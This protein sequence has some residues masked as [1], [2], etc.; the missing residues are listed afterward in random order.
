MILKF[1]TKDT[2]QHCVACTE[3]TPCGWCA[4]RRSKAGQEIVIVAGVGV[5]AH[6]A[7]EHACAHFGMSQRSDFDVVQLPSLEG[8]TCEVI[9]LTRHGNDFLHGGTMRGV[10]YKAKK[11]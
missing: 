1:T 11:R 2:A 5:N 9:D 6:R 8:V 7:F 3:E 10:H 4:D